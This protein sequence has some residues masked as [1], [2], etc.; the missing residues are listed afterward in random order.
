M[1]TN[2]TERPVAA[3]NAAQASQDSLFVEVPETT[4]RGSDIVVPAFLVAKYMSS[5][6]AD[7]KAYIS[8]T[9]KPAVNINV[10]DSIKAAESAGLE[11]ITNLRYL[12]LAQNIC[13]T[14]AN[15]TSW[16]VGEGK[17]R[18]GLRKG[19]VDEVQANDYEPADSDECR[20]FLLPTGERVYDV[21]GHLY[22]WVRADV[23]GDPETGLVNAP[24]AEGSPSIATAPYPSMEKGMGW[25]PKAGSDWSGHALVRGGCFYSDGRS[26][27]FYLGN[28]FPGV[29]LDIIGFRCT[30]PR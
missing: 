14:A 10:Y 7:N 9:E 30:K 15:W 2:I 19:T 1:D 21:A 12:A 26:G 16:T 29:E 27:V 13:E 8:A 11:L 24:F 28:D 18:Q 5:V 4:L 6:D 23:E 25:Y 17:L 3:I 20:W 22:S